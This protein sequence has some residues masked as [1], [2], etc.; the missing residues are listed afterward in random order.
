MLPKDRQREWW[1]LWEDEED[2]VKKLLDDLRTSGDI[3]NLTRRRSITLFGE[4]VL[5]EVMDL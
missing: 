2:D 3:G 1:K 5:E 4:L